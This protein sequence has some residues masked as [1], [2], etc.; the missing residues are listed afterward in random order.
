[1]KT[2]YAV[3]GLETKNGRAKSCGE[4]CRLVL[5][6]DSRRRHRQSDN[7]KATAQRAA[8]RD[9]DKE[10]DSESRILWLLLD[11]CCHR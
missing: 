9:K 6:R 11:R 10:S 5:A 2:T 8:E 1:M 7:G 4:A 3:C